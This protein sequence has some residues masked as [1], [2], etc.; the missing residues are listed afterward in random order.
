M[1]INIWMILS[2][3]CY[4]LVYLNSNAGLITSTVSGEFTGSKYPEYSLVNGGGA[5]GAEYGGGAGG[6]AAAE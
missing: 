2:K 4:D 6:D 1:K 3:I 5:G